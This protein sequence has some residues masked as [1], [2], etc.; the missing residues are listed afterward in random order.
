MVSV[1]YS[2]STALHI[3]KQILLWNIKDI[4]EQIFI[5]V[6]CSGLNFFSSHNYNLTINRLIINSTIKDILTKRF[7]CVLLLPY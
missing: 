6:K 2:L 1:T 7:K 5:K 4:D 3:S